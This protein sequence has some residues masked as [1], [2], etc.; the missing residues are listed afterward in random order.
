MG[1]ILRSK[2]VDI[3]KAIKNNYKKPSWCTKALW[4]E[5]KVWY[6]ANEKKW[7]QQREARRV[8]MASQGTHKLGSGGRARFKA[9]FVS[10]LHHTSWKFTITLVVVLNIG[11]TIT[12]WFLCVLHV[13]KEAVGRFPTAEEIRRAREIGTS[14]YLDKIA[15]QGTQVKKVDIRQVVIF[16][17][18]LFVMTT[19]V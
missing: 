15:S 19:I 18:L 1:K 9:F 10:T 6:P 5:E 7:S 16:Y 11:F 17:L 4:E 14:A 8:Q 12:L 13:Q 3:V 2:H